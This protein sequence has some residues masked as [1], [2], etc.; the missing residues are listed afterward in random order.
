MTHQNINSAIMV[1]NTHSML[2]PNFTPADRENLKHRKTNLQRPT[3]LLTSVWHLAV[4]MVQG[5]VMV[6][7]ASVAAHHSNKLTPSK[8]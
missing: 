5:H 8:I 6:V 3:S 4:A 2:L 7:E 1:A